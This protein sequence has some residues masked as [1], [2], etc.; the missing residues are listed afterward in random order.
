MH[1]QMLIIC[2]ITLFTFMRQPL[3]E[4]AVTLFTSLRVFPPLARNALAHI[5]T[6]HNTTILCSCGNAPFR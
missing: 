4:L 5:Y 3:S 6:V 2:A 1:K